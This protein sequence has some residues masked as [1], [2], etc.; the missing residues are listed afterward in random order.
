MSQVPSDQSINTV[1]LLPYNSNKYGRQAIHKQCNMACSVYAQ[2]INRG[3]PVF[4][5]LRSFLKSMTPQK[6]SQVLNCTSSLVAHTAK[7]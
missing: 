5:P 1:M 6:L 3:A 7:K 4:G 2:V